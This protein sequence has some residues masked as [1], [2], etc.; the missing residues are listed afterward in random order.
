[1]PLC[2]CQSPGGP[3]KCETAAPLQH[4][5]TCEK[6]PLGCRFDIPED[7][8]CVCHLGK[9]CRRRSPHHGCICQEYGVEHCLARQY[10]NCTCSKDRA[11]CRAERDHLCSCQE[12][13]TEGCLYKL[14]GY[15]EEESHKCTC[16]SS[17]QECLAKKSV[18]VCIC[19]SDKK[20]KCRNDTCEFC[21]CNKKGPRLCSL[22]KW[23]DHICTKNLS[24][25]YEPRVVRGKISGSHVRCYKC[26]EHHQGM[27]L[28][29]LG[30]LPVELFDKVL[31][32]LN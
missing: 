18:H 1:M 11:S 8:I 31:D 3:E 6:D 14:T 10:H 23:G 30:D 17:T 7:H 2:T 12:H 29:P 9:G 32:Y 16:P 20:E 27:P 19:A 24:C 4:A 26:R 22:F 28:E 21:V 15:E 13:G 25:Y 5:C